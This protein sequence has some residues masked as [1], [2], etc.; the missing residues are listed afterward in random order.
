MGKAQ[1]MTVLTCYCME[2]NGGY[3]KMDILTSGL[4]QISSLNNENREMKAA[5]LLLRVLMLSIIRI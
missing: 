3:W 1:K 2:E 5:S 4:M